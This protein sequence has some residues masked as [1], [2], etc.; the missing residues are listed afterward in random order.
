MVMD[1]N[2]REEKAAKR[3]ATFERMRRTATQKRDDAPAFPTV[4]RGQKNIQLPVSNPKLAKALTGRKV[5]RRV[6][7]DQHGRL[8]VRVSGPRDPGELQL[9]EE[10]LFSTQHE[11]LYEQI[12]LEQYVE[13]DVADAAVVSQAWVDSSLA[14][15]E[16]KMIEGRGKGEGKYEGEYQGE[17]EDECNGGDEFNG[18][19]ECNCDG[20]DKCDSKDKDK[21]E[22]AA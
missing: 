11:G 3:N 5:V 20:D 9:D 21:T 17:Y 2:N 13:E 4:G 10:K 8:K 6:K 7:S 16:V 19:D 15:A 1:A 18:D 14:H 22:S 12:D